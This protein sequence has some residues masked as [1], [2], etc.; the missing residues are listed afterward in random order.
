M[1]FRFVQL[2]ITP[3]S[4]NPYFWLLITNYIYLAFCVTFLDPNTIA[5]C[6]IRPTTFNVLLTVHVLL[7]VFFEV[8]VFA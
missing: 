5:L 1:V 6:C 8:H 4:H 2:I 7:T 3:Q